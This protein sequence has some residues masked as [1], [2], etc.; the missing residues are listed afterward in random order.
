[1]PAV[2]H[3]MCR[4]PQGAEEVMRLGGDGRWRQDNGRHA[5]AFV[6]KLDGAWYIWIPNCACKYPAGCPLGKA[7]DF[8]QEYDNTAIVEVQRR[9]AY[10]TIPA[11]RK[12]KR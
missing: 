11:T 9:R 8:V 4:P 2:Q 10:R 5:T 12:R 6:G 3:N 1:M 7:L